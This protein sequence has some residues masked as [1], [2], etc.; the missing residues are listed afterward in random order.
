MHKS[1]KENVHSKQFRYHKPVLQFKLCMYKVFCPLTI[2]SCHPLSNNKQTNT[3]T[4][5]IVHIEMNV[6]QI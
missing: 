5:P 1:P 4:S 6:P 3:F 2:T